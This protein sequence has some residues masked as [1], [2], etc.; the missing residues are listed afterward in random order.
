VF[1]TAR[2]RR[3]LKLETERKASFH[4]YGPGTRQFSPHRWSISGELSVLVSVRE[5]QPSRVKW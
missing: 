2:F 5:L 1:H 3:L 4:S